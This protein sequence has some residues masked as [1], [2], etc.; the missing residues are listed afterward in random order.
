MK[1]D[2]FP[3]FKLVRISTRMDG[4]CFFHALAKAYYK[5]YITGILNGEP[6]D[7][8]A[9]VT[10]LRK[11]LAE[12]LPVEYEKLAG[13]TLKKLGKDV[14]E[15]RLENMQKELRSN[16]PVSNLYNEFISNALNLDIY[17]LDGEKKDVY[18]TG[19]DD[20]LLYKNRRSVVILY[21]PGHYELVSLVSPSGHALTLFS[22]KHPFISCI[23]ERMN[24]LR[25]E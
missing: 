23:K 6:F 8:D 18:M 17:I 10:E 2:I 24:L 21:L 11:E 9:F 22:P 13:G 20:S 5:P 14:L 15:C 3:E 25:S 16:E 7:R 4:N 1:W 19:T 12:T